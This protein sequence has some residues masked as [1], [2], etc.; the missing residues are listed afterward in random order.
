MCGIVGYLGTSDVLSTI[1]SLLVEVQHRGQEAAG[2]ALISKEGYIKTVKSR[3]YVLDVF[4][5][6]SIK[7]L[8]TVDNVIGGIGHVRYS[9]T[10]A[11]LD[12][13]AQPITVGNDS[14]RIAIAFNG[15]IANYVELAKEFKVDHSYGDAFLLAEVIYKLALEYGEDVVEAL[16]IL[17]NYVVGGYSIAVITSEPR[18]VIA[19]DPYGFRPLAYVVN[20]QEFVF[21]SETSALECI[22][23]N[24]W[25]EVP[26]G[27]I[28]SFNDYS[29]ERT[30]TSLSTESTPCIFEYVYFS[31][32]DSIFNGIN[33]YRARVN[34]GVEL[35]LNSSVQGDVVIP[36]P[37]SS[38]PAAIG[39][40]RA[41]GIPL[42]EGIVANK[43]VGRGFIAPPSIREILSRLKY[44]FVK[45]AVNKKRVVLIDDSIVRGTT[46]RSIVRR[47]REVGAREVHVRISSP[48][49]KFPCFMGIDVA[50]RRELLAWRSASL[51][52]IAKSIEA[53]SVWYNTVEGLRKSVGLPSACFA[54][55]TGLYPFKYFDLEKMERM[56]VR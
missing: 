40:S 13:Q 34:M 27:G 18:M 29:I 20:D 22:G 46:M 6:N 25:R 56:I 43:Y 36:V 48:P 38:R 50:S 54:C 8:N 16:K 2:I 45:D 52:D 7:I 31:R 35:A 17:P 21:A 51:E 1:I 32:Q 24:D 4:N 26:A 15:T 55:F 12:Y 3:G 14:Y 19:R 37:D 41:S 9:T 30:S 10:G 5:E 47:L 23:L 49:F 28:I 33:I 44:G 42:E 39:F 53:D 11:Y